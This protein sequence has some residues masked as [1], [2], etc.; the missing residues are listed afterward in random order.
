MS[1]ASRASAGLLPIYL[2]GD[3]SHQSARHRLQGTWIHGW[4][5]TTATEST[6]VD[7]AN[8]STTIGSHNVTSVDETTAR[9]AGRDAVRPDIASGEKDR[10]EDEDPRNDHHGPSQQLKEHL[11][12]VL[13]RRIVVV[14][15][16]RILSQTLAGHSALQVHCEKHHARS[17]KVSAMRHPSGAFQN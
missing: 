1:L 13:V 3:I 14:A 6:S 10:H 4:E 9:L 11:V 17:R 2:V 16:G 8:G 5:R 12:R 15:C 7:A